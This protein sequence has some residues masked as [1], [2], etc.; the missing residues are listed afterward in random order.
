MFQ[1]RDDSLLSLLGSLAPAEN[2]YVSST[3]R[4]GSGSKEDLSLQ[5]W[6]SLESSV[7]SL[8]LSG[9]FSDLVSL[10]ATTQGGV[11]GYS[12]HPESSI[13]LEG[14]RH[15]EQWVDDARRRS[16]DGRWPNS[17]EVGAVT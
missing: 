9:E 17:N 10:G 4:E 14:S 2:S 11:G 7:E 13:A 6:S 1:K 12:S 16:E 15:T 8:R 5:Q 3:Q